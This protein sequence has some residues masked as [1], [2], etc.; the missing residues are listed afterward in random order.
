MNWNVFIQATLSNP[1]NNLV[2]AIYDHSAPGVPVQVIAP[3]K[4]YASTIHIIFTGIDPILYDFKLFESA[5][6]SPAG[7]VRSSFS[8][9][10]TN[11][12]ITVR[13]DL[14]LTAGTSVNFNA[15]A[16]SYTADSPNDLT[17]WAYDLERRGFGTMEPGVN[18]AK[19]VNGFHLLVAGD[20]FEVEEKFI[21]HFL[22]LVAQIPL[23]TVPALI[24]TT[25]IITASRTLTN[26]DV[27]KGFLI[28]GAGSSITI[29]LPALSLVGNNKTLFFLSAGGS[30]INAIIQCAGSD[31]IE[32]KL[33]TN[34]V[35]PTVNLVLGQSEQLILIKSNSK[36]NV[37][38]SSDT[39]R[40]VGEVIDQYSKQQINT[41]F[42]SGTALSRADY[43]RLWAYVQTL[44]AGLVIADSTYND[45]SGSN[46][47]NR[48]KYTTGNGTTTFRIPTLF[49]HGFRKAVDSVRLP[50]SFEADDVKPHVHDLTVPANKTSSTQAGQ[51]RF[52]GGS[53]S[54]EPIPMS[55][56]TTDNNTGTETRPKNT[57]IYA[58]IRI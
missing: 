55:P 20:Q 16:T 49:T 57:G 32:Y 41:I 58:L 45:V 23:P 15:G 39:I 40:M 18:Y 48:G 37:L 29:I 24:S 46:F 43:P 3:P 50:G 21:L 52:V 19:D 35:T 10:P 28:Q 27:G 56:V 9:E 2:A 53:D 6:T 1:A 54:N 33:Y 13:D 47:I 38:M 42:A 7:T 44:E 5:T 12:S 4:P 8:F 14:Y 25:E 34:Q 36:W 17:G 30:H 51:G 11:E 26:A 22:P 31:A